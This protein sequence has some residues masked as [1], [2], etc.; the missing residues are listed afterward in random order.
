MKFALTFLAGLLLGCVIALAGLYF[1]PL[2]KDQGSGPGVDD[3]SLRY[4]Q[5]SDDLLLLT[6]SGSL[7]LPKAPAGAPDLWE[8]TLRGTL[9]QVAV[10]RDQ[11]GNAALAS[12]ISISRGNGNMMLH[13]LPVRDT[14]LV[15]V[16]G[17]GSF[18]VEAD[19][20]LWPLMR[21]HLLP[22]W[23]LGRD[24][25]GPAT[26]HTVT[27]PGLRNTAIVQGLTGR[28][29]GLTGS[30]VEQLD[31]EQVTANAHAMQLVGALHVRLTEP[32]TD[33]STDAITD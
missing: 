26:V 27:G 31:L 4:A 19:G 1:N 20:N 30:A 18:T 8:R 13:G 33:S 23:Y 11:A 24:W 9:V 29:A 28:F 6:H 25:Q 2:V 22:V 5:P 12:R 10:L 15:T 21:D 14:W 32:V 16:P 7:R 17:Q 3:W